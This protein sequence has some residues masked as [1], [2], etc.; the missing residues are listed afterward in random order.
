MK[1]NI[2]GFPG[3]FISREG[4]LYSR[5][6]NKGRL[7]PNTWKLRKGTIRKNGLPYIVYG[8]CLRFKRIKCQKYAH[9]LVA[10]TYIPNPDNLPVVMHLDNNP[11]NNNVENLK[12][13]TTLENNQQCSTEGR[14]V[15]RNVPLAY[16]ISDLHIGQY[17]KFTSR[18]DTALDIL[19]KLGKKCSKHHVP[20]IHCGDLFHSSDKMDPY[21]LNRVIDVFLKLSK[22]D[23]L[24]INITGN[25][26]SPLTHKVNE[27]S[28]LLSYDQVIQ[29]L[30]SNIFYNLDFKK[31][32]I[33]YQHHTI[34]GVPYIDHNIGLNSYL[35]NLVLNPNKKN[36]LLLH[37]D[38]PGAKDTDGRVV[39]SAENINLNMLN[40]FDLVLCGHIHKPQR[41]SK[42]VYMLGAPIQQRRTD[43][44]CKMGYWLVMD[45]LSMK[46]VELK[47]FPKFIDVESE[48]EVND[49]GNYYTVIP[50]KS[51]EKV[52]TNHKIT[53]TLS[54]KK[55]AK[56]YLKEKGIKDRGKEDL[57]IKILKKSE[58]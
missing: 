52:N 8:F 50:K 7:T 6:D 35:K 15:S 43:K 42:K 31:I 16:V 51:S 37:T 41:L 23:F 9:R 2:K 13:G 22:L 21:L 57:L 28:S 48:D 20:L 11:Q 10:E 39:D 53:K 58:V 18:L 55:L 1:D 29:K 47:G 46:F 25:H 30:F 45:D 33:T 4:L 24:M 3:Y 40:R 14:H 5:Y 19:L 34:Y 54:K 17:G 36:I 49:D 44:D 26:G 12:W 56:R 27:P 38:Y 32:P